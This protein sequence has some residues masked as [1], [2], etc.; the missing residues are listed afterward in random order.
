M[1]DKT[2]LWSDREPRG[3]M[4]GIMKDY[5]IPEIEAWLDSF[6]STDGRKCAHESKL[7][8]MKI[9]MEYFGHPEKSSPC[10][11][12]AGSKGKGTI[13]MSV[14][15]ILT[16][17]G[18]KVG[19]FMS[20]HV[21]HFTERIRMADGPFEPE[22]Y[23]RAFEILRNGVDEIL[24][25]K[26]LTREQL[27]WFML[28][29]TLAMLTFREA[30]V[31]YAVY[32]VGIGGRL[33]ATNVVEPIAIGMGEIELEHTRLLG[34]T[35]EKIAFEKAGIFKEKV[36]IFSV[37]QTN[38]ARSVFA[39]KAK[40]MNA[41]I[42]YIGPREGDDYEEDDKTVARMMVRSAYPGIEDDVIDRGLKKMKLPGRY[43]IV[44]KEDGVPYVLLDGAHTVKSLI[45]VCRR[46]KKSEVHGVLI[47][48]CG[49]KER[50]REIARGIVDSGL[51]TKIFLTSPGEKKNFETR[52]FEDAFR[53]AGKDVRGNSD[54]KKVI[55]RAFGYAREN[56]EAVI[57][58]GSFYLVGEVK[59]YLEGF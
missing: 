46:M 59:K 15:C 26:V 37:M 6:Q 20:P 5:D 16:E 1:W 12:V 18:K 50:N 54:Y 56:G 52:K 41:E 33:D 51:F 14:A 57:V 55:Q 9:L 35:I 38:E 27:T 13:A 39:K 8:T 3:I 32:E 25:K 40:E 10:F 21:L 17:A 47:F 4:W 49:A 28:V 48:G 2:G 42:K 53:V 11:H 30:K 22:V 44:E 7:E 29:T 23:D 45:E 58:L 36:P 43:E 34:N 19:V 24:D 31:D